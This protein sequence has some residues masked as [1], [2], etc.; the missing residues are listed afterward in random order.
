VVCDEATV[1]TKRDD[2][3][4]DKLVRGDTCELGA[5]EPAGRIVGG[6]YG[7]PR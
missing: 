1:G 2:V 6:Q 3:P 7:G 5:V 4:R